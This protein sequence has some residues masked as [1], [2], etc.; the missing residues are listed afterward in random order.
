MS[1]IRLPTYGKD[2]LEKLEQFPKKILKF[3]IITSTLVAI[4]IYYAY[5]VTGEKTILMALF[6]VLAMLPV[7]IAIIYGLSS[8]YYKRTRKFLTDLIKLLEPE[9]Y[10]ILRYAGY[11]LISAKRKTGEIVYLLIPDNT[12]L[13][14]VIVKEFV[15]RQEKNAKSIVELASLSLYLSKKIGKVRKIF[16][17]NKPTRKCNRLEEEVNGEIRILDPYRPVIEYG[18][19]K[20]IVVLLRCLKGLG[21]A[22]QEV[23]ELV[24]LY[25]PDFN[26]EFL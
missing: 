19:G 10:G 18:Y 11:T 5:Y 7:D 8:S 24:K 22:Y 6:I 17:L 25:L 13:Y 16:K 3:I 1:D 23:E 2:A 26:E 21:S 14:L 4:A 15:P 12:R 20:A 9:A